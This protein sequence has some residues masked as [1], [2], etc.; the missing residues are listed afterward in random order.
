MTPS[1]APDTLTAPPCNGPL[2]STADQSARKHDRAETCASIHLNTKHQDVCFSPRSKCLQSVSRLSSLCAALLGCGLRRGLIN[3][4]SNTH[5][6]FCKAHLLHTHMHAHER[7]YMGVYVHA[8]GREVAA[9]MCSS[10]SCNSII[11]TTPP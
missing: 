4:Q 9:R 5:T 2:L 1:P 8:F 10:R 11:P 7:I 3:A 6:Y